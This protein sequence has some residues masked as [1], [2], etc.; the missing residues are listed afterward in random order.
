MIREN[1]QE[2]MDHDP[3]FQ[4]RGI[5]V[6]RIEN[7]SDIVFALAL[8]MLVSSSEPPVRFDELLNFLLNIVPVSAGFAIL[9]GIWSAH[10]TFFRRYGLKDRR[11]IFLNALLL[12]VVLFLAY[13]LRFIFDSLFNYVLL[14]WGY[15]DRAM[16][17]QN[18]YASSA[19]MMGLY[20]IGYAIVFL[21]I[22]RMYTHALKKK[23]QLALSARELFLTRMSVAIY[24]IQVVVALAIAA[25]SVFTS[26]GA[27]SG[28]FYFLI[29]PLSAIAKFIL[30]RG[31]KDLRENL[32]SG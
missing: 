15:Q 14:Q 28:V 23:E 13:P 1:L 11:T 2:V 22:A 25:L 29:W 30:S 9:L 3:D 31:D 10:Y 32:Q 21:I 8:G 17:V 24:Y 7:L 6:T 19:Y 12:L 27:F 4:W 26:V 16:E 20:S 5:E 18:T